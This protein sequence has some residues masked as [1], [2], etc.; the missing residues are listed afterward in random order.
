M[1]HE[2]RNCKSECAHA[3]CRDTTPHLARTCKEWTPKT[4]K[5]ANLLVQK[6]PWIH[7]D[8]PD[9]KVNSVTMSH[10]NPLGIIDE[11]EMADLDED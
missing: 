6:P 9:I 5:K 7:E 3:A 11:S 10:Y 8:E 1:G 4:P 2:L